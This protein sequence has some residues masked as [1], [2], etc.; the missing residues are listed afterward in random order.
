MRLRPDDGVMIQPAIRDAKG[1]FRNPDGSPAAQPLH[2]VARMMWEGKG[3]RWPQGL[4]NPPHPPPPAQVPAGHASFT[5]IGHAS[6]LIRL[7]DGTT[8]LTDPIFSER[9]SPFTWLGPKRVRPPALALEDLPRID[10]VLVSHGH[11]D[12][13]DLPS[14]RA[15]HARWRPRLLTGLG[16]AEFLAKNGIPGAI[17]LNW[18]ES[19]ELP[20]GHRATYVPMRHFSARGIRDRAHALWGGFA[21][22]ALAGGRFLFVGD[23]AAGGH[24]DVIGRAFGGFGVALIPIGAYAPLWFMQAV[25]VTPEQAVEAQAQLRARTALAMH[26]GTFQLT[27]EAMEEPA[28]RLLAARGGQDFRVP[29]FG[30]SLVLAI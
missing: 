19:A 9:C 13:M 2:R 1:R 29:G 24:L 23:T 30:E 21:V 20:G 16:H 12:H 26:F 8:I 6:F 5:F 7:A 4:R 10:A 11:Y 3:P 25:H 14:L 18:G 15:I 28:R 22:E 27:Q 17:E